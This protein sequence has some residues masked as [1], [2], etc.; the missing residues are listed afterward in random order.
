[1]EMD[2]KAAVRMG[3]PRCFCEEKALDAAMRVFWEKGYE[4]ASLTNLTGAMGIN[5]PSLYAAFGDKE[6]LFRKAMALYAEGPGAYL[7]QALAEPTARKVVETLWH[8]AVE[9]LGNPRN[10]RG[11]LSVQGGVA[12][13]TSAEP[14]RQTLIEWRKQSE[15]QIAERFARAQDEGDLPEHL[16]PK[17]LARYVVVVLNGLGIQAAN[18]VTQAEMACVVEMALGA[19]P[20]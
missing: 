2:Q 16:N 5:R 12:C 7:Q 4:G 11:C 3:R 19:L 13:G 18:G 20:I 10:P 1:M 14:I 6:T 17:D 9:Q 8:G 15:A